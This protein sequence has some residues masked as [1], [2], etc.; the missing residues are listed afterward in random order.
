[1]V[2]AMRV[3]HDG[4]ALT[5][6]IMF[7]RFSIDEKH[8]HATTSAQH[9]CVDLCPLWCVL[10][11]KDTLTLWIRCAS[12]KFTAWDSTSTN[13]WLKVAEGK[14][15]EKLITGI[16]WSSF[17]VQSLCFWQSFDCICFRL[18]SLF[19]L[20]QSHGWGTPW[21]TQSLSCACRRLPVA[22]RC[23]VTFHA[24][25]DKD[26]TCG[27]KAAPQL[28]THHFLMTAPANSL[29][30][31]HRWCFSHVHA[32]GDKKREIRISF[33]P[34]FPASKCCNQPFDVSCYSA[35]TIWNFKI[36]QENIS[37]WPSAFEDLQEGRNDWDWDITTAQPQTC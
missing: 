32:L 35:K 2:H 13:S 24:L 26:I 15:I 17:R 4:S 19:N 22:G 8:N 27:H 36:F 25:F 11:R 9:V 37:H 30:Q 33:P 10:L 6:S 18:L 12:R 29:L 28:N 7:V 23:G 5:F 21:H 1:M 16:H 20:K 31:S 34:S 14:S 3:M